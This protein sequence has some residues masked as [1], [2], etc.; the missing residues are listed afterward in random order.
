MRITKDETKIVG[1]WIF[2]GSKMIADE[3]CKRID[4]L[5]NNYLKLIST[6]GSGW[7]NLYQDPEDKRYWQLNFEHGEMQG[8]GPPTLILLSESE[9]KDKYNV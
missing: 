2:D 3:T 9:A 1:H 5:R 6:D 8:S 4:W 7:L